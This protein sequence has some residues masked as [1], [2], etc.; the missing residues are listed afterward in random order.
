MYFGQDIDAMIE[1]RNA[2][3][4]EELN[5]EP[6]LDTEDVMYQLSGVEDDLKNAMFDLGEAVKAAEGFPV[7]YRI[8][9][10][11]DDI[12]RLNDEVISLKA[13]IKEEVKST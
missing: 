11:M 7:E 1:A 5:Q 3:A 2:Q 6:I 4:W 10:I 9:S 8:K 12:N 13:R